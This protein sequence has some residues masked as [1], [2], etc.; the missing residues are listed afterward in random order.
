MMTW[1]AILKNICPEAIKGVNS[2]SAMV[3][4]VQDKIHF[5]DSPKI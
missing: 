3:H 1:D 2:L 4:L 5:D